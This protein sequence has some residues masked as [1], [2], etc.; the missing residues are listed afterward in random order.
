MAGIR[1]QA[2]MGGGGPARLHIALIEGLD[3]GV[4]LPAELAG[5]QIRAVD[6]RARGTLFL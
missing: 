1:P 4:A 5:Q 3:R 6:I 2:D